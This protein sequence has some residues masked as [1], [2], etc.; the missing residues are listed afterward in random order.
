MWLINIQRKSYIEKA[1][2]EVDEC[3]KKHINMEVSFAD[4]RK[5]S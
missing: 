1:K 5:K 4:D 2:T 3:F